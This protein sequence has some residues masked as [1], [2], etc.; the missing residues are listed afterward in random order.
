MYWPST[1]LH[2]RTY[3]TLTK[4]V[5]AKA[6]VVGGGMSGI[7]SAYKLASAGL[8]T[9][10]IER[11]T[12]AGGSTSANTGMLQY[13]SDMMLSELKERIGSGPAERYYK[14]CLAAIR[15]IEELAELIPR[16]VQFRRR[17]SLYYASTEQHVPK[18]K[19]E[20]EALRECGFD[21]EYWTADDIALHFPFRKPAALVTHGDAEL[22][23]LRF[24]LGLA[25]EAVKAG[26]RIYEGTDLAGYERLG[27][28]KR[29][30]RLFT[31][32]G[33]TLDADYVVYA[34]GYEPKE[35]KGRLMKANLNRSYVMVT[36]QQTKPFGWHERFLVWETARPY[37]YMRTT[38]DGRIIAGGL[39]EEK[40]EPDHNKA[41]RE[42]KRRELTD[43][44]SAMFPDASTAVDFE[45]NA[46]FGES[47]DSL[48]LI[49]EDPETPGIYYNLGYGG[50]GTVCC[51]MGAQIISDMIQGHAEHPLPF[52]G[53]RDLVAKPAH[54][55][56]GVLH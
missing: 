32:N 51:M 42:R 56:S 12:I 48:P 19:K 14:S 36:K 40:D 33:V 8:E 16:D 27:V 13:C 17:S 52:I 41:R 46:T 35:V 31:K 39:D 18:L 28:G 9:V 29:R 1:A 49:G 25:D 44:L 53:I 55:P 5:A 45:W 47:A 43:R 23:P 10:L 7:A 6:V 21:V 22:N 50:N 3:P 54:S 38:V 30:H 24:V 2:T 15:H 34:V 37:L 4:S 11:G 20:Y 26:L